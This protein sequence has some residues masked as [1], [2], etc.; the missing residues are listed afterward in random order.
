MVVLIFISLIISDVEHPFMCSLAIYMS[1]LE[2]VHLDLLPICPCFLLC[3]VFLFM[4]NCMNCLYIWEINPS[5]ASFAN[6][7]FYPVG[8][9]YLLFM[10]Y[11][12]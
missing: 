12:I 3:C 5:V 4:L 9:L 2:N 10:V 7:S 6:I 11:F 1:S 8:C